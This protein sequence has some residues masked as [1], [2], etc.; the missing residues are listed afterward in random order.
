MEQENKSCSDGEL[1]LHRRTGAYC[2]AADFL[3]VLDD[4]VGAA[5]L[6]LRTL[7]TRADSDDGGTGG[8]TSTNARRRVF[9]DDAFFAVEAEALGSEQEGV[10]GGLSGLEPLVAGGDGNWWWGNADSGHA[11]VS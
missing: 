6:D 1:Q 2:R 4:E 8:N 10:G 7:V 9:E 11:T 3:H 5:V